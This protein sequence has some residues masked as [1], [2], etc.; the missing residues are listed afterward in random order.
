MTMVKDPRRDAAKHCSSA[1]K[2]VARSL[3]ELSRS[4][5]STARAVT[6]ATPDAWH[7]VARQASSRG[8]F[9][10]SLVLLAVAMG[11]LATTRTS[12]FASG[13]NNSYLLSV[14]DK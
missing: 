13:T 4:A 7:E 2:Q 9:W 10:L 6:A 8:G 1:C 5:A 12:S 11:F 3:Q 14:Q